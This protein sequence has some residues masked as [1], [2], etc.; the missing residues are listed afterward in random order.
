MAVHVKHV[1]RVVASSGL[2]KIEESESAGFY[3]LMRHGN[4]DTYLGHL[5]DA[6]MRDLF[7]VIGDLLT[8]IDTAQPEPMLEQ[9]S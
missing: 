9:A 1:E 7:D 3:K 6:E 8:Y 4:V 5:T 2:M